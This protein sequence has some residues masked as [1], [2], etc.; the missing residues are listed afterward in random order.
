MEMNGEFSCQR[1]QTAGRGK[2]NYL[3]LLNVRGEDLNELRL[4]GFVSREVRNGVGYFK[5]RFRRHGRQVVIGLGKDPQLA[6]RIG[7]ELAQ[8][9]ANRQLEREQTHLIRAAHSLLRRTKRELEPLFRDAG[10]GFYGYEIRKL[11][12]EKQSRHQT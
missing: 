2:V 4:Q 9:Q 3:A 5:L 10:Y 7:H 8:L 12:G 1:G 11:R 6:E